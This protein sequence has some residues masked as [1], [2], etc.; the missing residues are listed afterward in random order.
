MKFKIGGRLV[1]K[2][3]TIY[4]SLNPTWD[5]TFT[6]LLDDPFELIH[7]KVRTNFYFKK[8]CKTNKN[9]IVCIEL[10]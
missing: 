9:Y 4:K 3:K 1:H 2:S 8:Q 6:Y 5:E 10:V 7:I